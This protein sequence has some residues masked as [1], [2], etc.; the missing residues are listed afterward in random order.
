[1]KQSTP[2]FQDI[3]SRWL[4]EMSRVVTPTTVD[5]YRQ[6]LEK[7]VY[8]VV[9]GTLDIAEG[10]VRALMD[11]LL[12]QG[13]SE[14]TV[15]MIPRL[16]NRVL[17]FAS[18]EGLCPPPQWEIVLG[19]ARSKRS[20]VTL[21]VEE[22]RTLLS[23]LQEHPSPMHL[24]LYLMLTAGLTRK[25][26]VAL[27]WADVSLFLKQIQVLM[28]EE[29]TPDT[30]NKYRIIPVNERQRI[31]LKQMQAAPDIFVASGKDKPIWGCNL[32][33][34]LSVITQELLLPAAVPSDLRRTFAV[35]CLE[36]GMG[37][38]ELS[39][40]LGVKNTSIFRTQFRALV[41]DGTGERL[42][43]EVRASRKEFQPPRS[44]RSP[45]KDPEIRQLEEK[46]A[47]RK[48]QLKETLASLEGDLE[49]IRSLRNR[50]LV[51][52]GRARE[53]FNAF[54]QKVLGDDRDGQ[55]V[56][57]YLRCN[58]RVAEMPSRKSIGIPALRT[59]I[60]RGFAKLESRLDEIY[61]VEGYDVLGYFHQLAARVM[62][63]DPAP[64][65]NKRGRPRKPT[66][67]NEFK[68]AMKALD[69]LKRT[70][71]NTRD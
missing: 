55:A 47:A 11:G 9:G 43:A 20:A 46:V 3:A 27:R 1:M 68:V 54:V 42:D 61:A 69:R 19:A 62:E 22:E 8:P 31:Y 45:E 10:D 33:P 59:R 66:L 37:Y 44:H 17:S 56:V 2:T 24:G 57:E 32:A 23:Y 70:D 58:L 67:E 25:E 29:T 35:R 39:K 50:D 4:A 12:G 53:E 18:A 5:S 41:T 6:S 30:R 40:A 21:T 60:A 7:Y 48:K 26:V 36:N 52:Q 13:L 51:A 71:D 38:E 65:A 16:V 34:A 14:Q 49:I 63:L 64:E 15:F 28:E